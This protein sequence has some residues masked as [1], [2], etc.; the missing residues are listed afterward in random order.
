MLHYDVQCLMHAYS[1]D[2]DDTLY[3]MMTPCTPRWYLIHYKDDLM[4]HVEWWVM[5]IYW[6]AALANRVMN[7][8]TNRHWFADLTRVMSKLSSRRWCVDL[9]R[10][11]SKSGWEVDW[12]RSE[13][14][15]NIARRFFHLRIGLLNPFLV[16]ANKTRS[17]PVTRVGALFISWCWL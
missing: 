3:T 4:M 7:R 14:G 2:V 13:I 15:I 8:L 5:S 1:Y 6:I 16:G 12:W 10:L 9:I 17:S 11:M